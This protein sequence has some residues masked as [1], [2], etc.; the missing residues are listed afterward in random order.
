MTA[1]SPIAHSADALRAA[2]PAAARRPQYYAAGPGNGGAG[3]EM[4]VLARR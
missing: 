1:G 3:P 4:A 2:G